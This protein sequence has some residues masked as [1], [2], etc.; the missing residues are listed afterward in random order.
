MK[1][2]IRKGSAK[3]EQCNKAYS[4]PCVRHRNLYMIPHCS[5]VTGS[6]LK[7]SEIAEPIPQTETDHRF[8]KTGKYKTYYALNGNT[9]MLVDGG[10]DEDGE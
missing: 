9:L 2:K 1:Q 7:L 5:K 10:D 4:K 3:R 6:W 8:L